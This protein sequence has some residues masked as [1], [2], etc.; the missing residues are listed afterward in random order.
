MKSSLDWIGMPVGNQI[1][2]NDEQLPVALLV[3]ECFQ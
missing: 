2:A 3:E 1:S